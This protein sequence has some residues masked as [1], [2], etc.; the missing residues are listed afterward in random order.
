[1]RRGLREFLVRDVCLDSLKECGH[2]AF[3]VGT[4]G[5][6][7]LA[8]TEAVTQLRGG[9]DVLQTNRNHWKALTIGKIEFAH[10]LNGQRCFRENTI[11]ITSLRSMAPTIAVDHEL[12]IIHRN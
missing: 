7:P 9:F 12:V 6:Q 5:I 3:P 11:T 2:E 8:I 4:D 1:L 10:D